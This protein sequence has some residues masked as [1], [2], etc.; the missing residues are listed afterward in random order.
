MKSGKTDL[1]VVGMMKI[2]AWLQEM[3]GIQPQVKRP[4]L[5]LNFRNWK[6]PGA[7]SRGHNLPNGYKE[8]ETV[9]LRSGDGTAYQKVYRVLG[10]AFSSGVTYVLD[11][12]EDMQTNKLCTWIKGISLSSM[13]TWKGIH[14]DADI[15]HQI[16]VKTPGLLDDDCNYA[17]EDADV[18]RHIIRP[19][20]DCS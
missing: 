5:E 18:L 9:H 8:V 12:E 1:D 14:Y 7:L 10:R 2:S 19:S 17:S 3:L 11:M 4:W 6:K 15:Y 16:N 13:N 20:H